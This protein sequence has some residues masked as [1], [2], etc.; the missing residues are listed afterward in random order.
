MALRGSV[1][2]LQFLSGQAHRNH[3]RWLRAAPRT[4]TTAPPQLRNVVAGFSLVCP[5][6]DLLVTYHM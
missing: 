5:L 2:S 3:L 6:L 1:Q 4:T